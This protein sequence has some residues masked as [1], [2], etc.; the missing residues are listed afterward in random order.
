MAEDAAAVRTRLEQLPQPW[1]ERVHRIT[2]QEYEATLQYWAEKHPGT[3]AVEK[4]GA[5]AGGSPIFLVRVTDA[6]VA[7]TDKQIALVSC[8]HSGPERSGM[9]TTMHLVEWLL[10][11][12]PEAVQTRQRQIVLVM[13]VIT[14]EALFE[15]DRFGN[16]NGIDPYSGMPHAW[17]LE[18][19]TY[20]AL[21]KAPEIAAILAVID[22][23]Q[24]DVILDLHGTGLQELTPEQ[25]GD[26]TMYQGQTMGEASGTA[27]SNYALR[28][29]DWR[30]A[31]AMIA[32]AAEAGYGS[33]RAEA[34]AQRAF[35]GPA[36]QP[37][38]DR[39]WSGQSKFYTTQYAY[40]K[41]HTLLTTMEIGWEESGVARVRG[42]LRLGNEPWQ[43]EPTPGYPV[44]R[45]K[46]FV[47]QFLTAWG[48]NAQE[49]RRSRIELWQQQGRFTQAFLYPQTDGRASHIVALT[50]EAGKLIDADKGRFLANLEGLPGFD[51]EA[52]RAFFEVGPEAKLYTESGTSAKWV[53]PKP[54]EH[55]LGIRLRLLYRQ[56]KIAD[57]RVNGHAIAES[58][59]DGYQMWY[60][61]GQTQLQI[62]LP[63]EKVREMP[64][65][66]VTCAYVPDVERHIGWEPPP[67]VQERL[68]AAGE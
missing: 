23:Y 12:S 58:P 48:R 61:D 64:L 25:L 43:G 38:A 36:V 8:T 22:R 19:M 39:L 20:P 14:P 47:G 29:W 11:D 16:A 65:V 35:S 52:I 41:Y 2:R 17:D 26:R 45:V 67:E 53:Q 46:A 59:T 32:A 57:L 4:V 15:T 34:D 50:E 9:T 33:D 30:V 10:G 68:K 1:K 54:I 21:D 62:H 60:A 37:I 28:P 42:M 24:P 7:D 40:A 3:C 56:P 49:R 18:K 51:V 66:V 5:S 63:P 6:A 31:E 55:G 44:D 13:P 27:Y